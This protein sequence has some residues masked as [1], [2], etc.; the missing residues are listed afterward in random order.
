MRNEKREIT[1]QSPVPGCSLYDQCEYLTNFYFMHNFQYEFEKI[2]LKR[3]MFE[4]IRAI[5]IVL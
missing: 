5:R 1:I 2:F 4:I 3:E